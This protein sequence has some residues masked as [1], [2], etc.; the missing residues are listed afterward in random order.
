MGN[1]GRK[2]G[3]YTLPQSAFEMEGQ[4]VLTM[5]L[6]T[7]KGQ[8]VVVSRFPIVHYAN[9]AAKTVEKAER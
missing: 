7:A 2:E 8:T 9:L 4:V 3:S 5:F 6:Q 1:D